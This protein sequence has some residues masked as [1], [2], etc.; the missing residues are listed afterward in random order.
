MEVCLTG[1][2]CRWQG[3][4]FAVSFVV[5]FAA[6]GQHQREHAI[7]HRSAPMRSASPSTATSFSLVLLTAFNFST[8]V[9]AAAVF[10]QHNWVCDT[11]VN[12]FRAKH[13]KRQRAQRST[14]WGDRFAVGG[15]GNRQVRPFTAFRLSGWLVREAR[16]RAGLPAHPGTNRRTVGL[17]TSSRVNA[18]GFDPHFY[19]VHPAQL[20]LTPQP[21]SSAAGRRSC[22]GFF[23][24]LPG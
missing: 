24:W 12:V 9:A 15:S 17:E 22:R 4:R 21:Q 11:K 5:A 13:A 2:L 20:K 7:L 16:E 6:V 1:A 19:V 18:A 3:G 8:K 14:G 23:L 10:L